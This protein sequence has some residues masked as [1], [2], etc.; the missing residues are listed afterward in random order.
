MVLGGLEVGLPRSVL[1]TTGCPLKP[2]VG[3]PT[4][5]GHSDPHAAE[6]S[7]VLCF[8]VTTVTSAITESYGTS[9]MGNIS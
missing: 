7:A 4:V 3:Q 2:T 8:A 9:G 6:G 5:S 1:M